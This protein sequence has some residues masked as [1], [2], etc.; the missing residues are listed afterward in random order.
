MMICTCSVVS[1]NS[2]SQPQ[3]TFHHSGN[4]VGKLPQ[5]YKEAYDPREPVL[6]LSSVGELSEEEKSS[7]RRNHLHHHRT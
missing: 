1:G 3:S 7:G 2:A 6:W 4:Y 5:E